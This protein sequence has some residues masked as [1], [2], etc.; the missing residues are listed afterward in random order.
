MHSTLLPYIILIISSFS[1][2]Q[3]ISQNNFGSWESL[4]TEDENFNHE[5]QRNMPPDFKNPWNEEKKQELDYRLSFPH[6]ED[7]FIDII[8]NPCGSNSTNLQDR[9]KRVHGYDCCMERFGKGEYGFL[10]FR[11][12]EHQPISRSEAKQRKL[13]AKVGEVSH[14]SFLVDEN[15]NDLT[16]DFSRQADDFTV[17]DE[18]CEGFRDP[19]PSCLQRRLRAVQSQYKPPCFDHNQTVDASS[20]CFTTDGILQKNCMQVGYTQNAYF[21]ICEG[22]SKKDINCGTYIEIH[23]ENGSPYDEESVPLSHTEIEIPFTNGMSTTTISLTYKGDENRILC[24]YRESILREGTTVMI[25]N[26]SARCCCPMSYQKLLDIGSYFCPK[27]TGM[28]PGPHS[29]SA[30]TISE[31]VEND[32]YQTLAPFCP[33][34]NDDEDVLM[35]SNLAGFSENDGL[36]AFFQSRNESLPEHLQN[37]ALKYTYRCNSVKMAGNG[38]FSSKDLSGEYDEICPFGGDFKTCGV[39]NGKCSGDDSAYSFIGEVGSVVYFSTKGR[40]GVTFNNGRTVYEFLEY[41]L[42]IIEPHNNYELWFV[43][44]NRFETIV[45]K[46]KRFQVTWPR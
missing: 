43:Q 42:K 25:T 8:I 41:Q 31:M 35:C 16:P 34:T 38:K 4:V 30:S 46:K 22:K 40:V 9:H 19:H 3:F 5:M 45:Q 36:R 27:K 37:Q 13:V 32:H 28:K 14:N 18:D 26:D 23:R 33:H 1:E 20:S 24:A 2:C 6:P 44:K 39:M 15:G 12:G 29:D 10:K 21:H 7:Y 17:I 11:P